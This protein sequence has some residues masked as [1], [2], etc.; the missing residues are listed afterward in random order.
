MVATQATA[1]IA[2]KTT[3]G[4]VSSL[5]RTWRRRAAGVAPLL[6]AVAATDWALKAGAVA[7]GLHTAPHARDTPWV[8]IALVLGVNFVWL[9][10]YA[11]TPLLRLALG[12]WF[13]GALGN[14]GELAA[15]GH[16]TNFIPMPAGYVAS[17]GDLCIVAGF[18]LFTGTRWW[19]AVEERRRKRRVALAS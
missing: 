15:H 12:L 16:V 1:L 3:M 13:G 8:L 17:P 11:P 19:R 9:V 4:N 18:A 5:V 14:F 6:I 7:T 2:R 10:A